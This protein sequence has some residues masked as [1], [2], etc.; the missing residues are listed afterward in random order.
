MIIIILL[1]LVFLILI[2]DESGWIGS[3]SHV[4]W[5]IVFLPFKKSPEINGAFAYLTLKIALPY[6]FV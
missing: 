2:L 5:E 3:S 6:C 1:Y 4:P